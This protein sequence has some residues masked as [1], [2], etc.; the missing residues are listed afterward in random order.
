MTC[1]RVLTLFLKSWKDVLEDIVFSRR[2]L[3]DESYLGHTPFELNHVLNVSWWGWVSPGSVSWKNSGWSL[4]ILQY[5][6][7]NRDGDASMLSKWMCLKVKVLK[8]ILI[9][10]SCYYSVSLIYTKIWYFVI[11]STV[12]GRSYVYSLKPDHEYRFSPVD[13]GFA[14][15]EPFKPNDN[16][17]ILDVSRRGLKRT[18]EGVHRDGKG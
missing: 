16:F 3:V 2:K 14:L 6:L 12:N 7:L 15:P 1:L 8:S 17:L 5:F 18:S 4:K 11:W 13:M 9:N 10:S